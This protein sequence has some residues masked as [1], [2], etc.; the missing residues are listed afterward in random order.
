MK[1]VHLIQSI[2][3]PDPRYVGLTSDLDA[4]IRAHNAGRSKHTSKL[5]PWKLVA[6]LG[7]QD[8]QRAVE[9]E[10]YLKTGSGHAFAKKHL[11]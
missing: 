8:E 6:Y 5:V 10:R 9:I 4:R 1:Y 2:A 7:F 11:W 3:F